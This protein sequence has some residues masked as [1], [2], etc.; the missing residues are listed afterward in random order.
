MPK[1][2]KRPS[3]LHSDDPADADKREQQA[4]IDADIE[5]LSRDPV[6]DQMVAEMKIQGLSPERRIKRLIAYFTASKVQKPGG[7]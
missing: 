6:A 3:L 7:P 1:S 5:G 2:S 4:H